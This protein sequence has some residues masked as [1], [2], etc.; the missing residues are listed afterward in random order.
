MAAKSAC[1]GGEKDAKRLRQILVATIQTEP[2]AKLQ[3]VSIAS[4]TTLVELE[5]VEDDALL[6]LAVYVG[7]TRLI[8]NFLLQNGEWMT[9]K[10]LDHREQF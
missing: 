9:G 1:E 4:P 5:I 2:L 8:D 6:S 10:K 7:T 3:Y